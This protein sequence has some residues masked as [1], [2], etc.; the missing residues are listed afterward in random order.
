MGGPAIVPR[1]LAHPL[2]TEPQDAL[3]CDALLPKTATTIHAP[4]VA[5]ICVFRVPRHMVFTLS[6]AC[7]WLSLTLLPG[8]WAAP[9]RPSDG[10]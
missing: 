3:L 10:R 1:S 4:T 7:R 8:P 5:A 6:P 9:G 2:P